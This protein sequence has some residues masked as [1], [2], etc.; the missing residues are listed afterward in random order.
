MLFRSR[1]YDFSTQTTPF[2]PYVAHPFPHISEFDSFFGVVDFSTQTTH[3]SH[4]SHT[5]FPHISEFNA[6]L[7][8]GI[9]EAAVGVSR[10][11]DPPRVEVGVEAS[12]DETLDRPLDRAHVD[13]AREVEVPVEQIAVTV[14]LSG[15]RPRPPAR[16][17][18]KS[19][20]MSVMYIYRL[21]MGKWGIRGTWVCVGGWGKTKNSG[22][23]RCR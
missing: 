17:K 19:T 21:R 20:Q 9:D 18:H 14:L 6:F 16:Q 10:W 15:P 11:F 12:A 7:E 13:A 22:D 2:L 8:G 5:P 3:F 1:V 4:M 23:T